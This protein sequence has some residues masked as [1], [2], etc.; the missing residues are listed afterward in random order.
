M[1]G[2]PAGSECACDSSRRRPRV[3]SRPPG[4]GQLAHATRPIPGIHRSPSR[5]STTIVLAE[6]SVD[7]ALSSL[8][9]PLIASAPALAQMTICG[10]ASMV[11]LERTAAA[12]RVIE[13]VS[14]T[15]IE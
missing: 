6:A 11:M 4:E 1:H 13:M 2:Q 9:L 3:V 8:R 14:G 12:G 15:Q 7:S 5:R 10:A